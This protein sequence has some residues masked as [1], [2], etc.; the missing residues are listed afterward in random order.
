MGA[1]GSVIPGIGTVAGAAVGGFVGSMVGYSISSILYYGALNTL[2]TV[3]ISYERRITIERIANEA[4][5][6][7]K[8]YIDKLNEFLI[9]S[10]KDYRENVVSLLENMQTC[11]FYNNVDGYISS[12]EKLGN[13]MGISLKIKT[14][15]EFDMY[16]EN[17]DLT[18]VF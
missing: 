8:K 3:D 7:N 13:I 12:I 11:I 4:I 2:K 5:N 6:E 10:Q 16:M 17:E 9:R 14:F 1:V 15:E 18:F